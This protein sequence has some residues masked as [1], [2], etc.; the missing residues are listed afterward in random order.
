M[1]CVYTGF[2]FS[3]K[4][5]NEVAEENEF[6][7]ARVDGEHQ[8]DHGGG[9]L[10]G[11]PQ[12]GAL[13]EGEADAVPDPEVVQDPRL[14]LVRDCAGVPQHVHRGCGALQPTRLAHR[15]PV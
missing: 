2:H 15:V 6:H 13:A 11:G 7:E 9:R 14:V 8:R 1:S 10:P 4:K 5:T 3:S 12:Q